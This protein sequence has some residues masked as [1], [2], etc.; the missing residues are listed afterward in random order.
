MSAREFIGGCLVA[1]VGI[2]FFCASLTSDLPIFMATG[3]P[4]PMFF[5]LIL[6]SALIGLGLF[7]VVQNLRSVEEI[8][9]SILNLKVF[10]KNFSSQNNLKYSVIFLILS[11]IYIYL[12]PLVGCV[13]S[14]FLYS[15]ILQRI[16]GRKLTEAIAISFV[17]LVVIY[18]LFIKILRVVF[19]EPL[20]GDILYLYF[21]TPL[22]LMNFWRL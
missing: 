14:T 15:T 11:G 1:A 13:I 20:I 8:W 9:N 12:F 16:F 18:L 6:S 2:S 17:V 5:P 4:G 10:M 21:S 3:V 7:Y 22:W 19:P